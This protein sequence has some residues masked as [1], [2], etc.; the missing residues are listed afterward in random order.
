MTDD[1]G[2]GARAP[3][4]PVIRAVIQEILTADFFITRPHYSE[5]MLKLKEIE[6]LI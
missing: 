1:C 2:A 3:T 6:L 5:L 4:G